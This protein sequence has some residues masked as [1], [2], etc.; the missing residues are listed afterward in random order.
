MISHENRLRW[1]TAAVRPPVHS[2][3]PDYCWI[4]SQLENRVVFKQDNGERR[5][6]AP[7]C[8]RSDE[9]ARPAGWG[10]AAA[11]D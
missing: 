9:L 8:V 4:A 11:T 7:M 5:G 3:D 6:R 1:R 10:G 2:T